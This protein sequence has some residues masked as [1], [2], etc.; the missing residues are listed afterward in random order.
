MDKTFDFDKTYSMLI[1]II[2]SIFAFFEYLLPNS[3]SYL[4]LVCC[5]VLQLIN[6]FSKHDKMLYLNSHLKISFLILLFIFLQII[7]SL[8]SIYLLNS[9]K[10]VVFRS[11]L[12]VI[13]ILM[14]FMDTWYRQG[15]KILFVFS[16]IHVFSTIWSLVSY[17][18]FSA[19]ILTRLPQNISEMSMF[20]KIRGSY[21]GITDQT[22]TN[23]YFIAVAVAIAFGKFL[24]SK[25]NKSRLKWGIYLFVSLV[26]LFLTSK[27]GA[28]LAVLISSFVMLA[29]YIRSQ[30]RTLFIKLL[31]IVPAV[32]LT[33]LLMFII[34]PDTLA[35]FIATRQ[36]LV[37]GDVTSGR[38]SLYLQAIDMFFEKPLLGW[39]SGVYNSLFDTGTH[40]AYLQVLSENGII[41]LSIFVIILIY[42]L[43]FTIKC[44][45]KLTTQ[46]HNIEGISLTFSIFYQMFFILDALTANSLNDGFVVIIYLLASSIPY[47]MTKNQ[48][49]KPKYFNKSSLAYKLKNKDA[50]PTLL[51][52]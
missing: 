28:L 11:L 52:R 42:N 24:G 34:F 48:Y 21:S 41:G 29:L 23:S 4:L 3:F 26:S 22:G 35:P 13:G 51:Y 8:R 46:V 27:R 40:N 37:S 32:L 31:K 43:Y 20:F 7:T 16:G 1:V 17:S 5:L 9:I 10:V 50:K 6:Q 19:L 25:N 36:K 38:F 2:I 44:Y 47:I 14:M 33:L 30:N 18:T 39:G 49:S 15:L 12:F 45:Q